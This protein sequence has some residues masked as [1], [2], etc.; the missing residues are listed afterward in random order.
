MLDSKI[1]EEDPDQIELDDAIIST[2]TKT[3]HRV[4]LT[5]QRASTIRVSTSTSM[6]RLPSRTSM[7]AVVTEQAGIGIL[8]DAS[9]SGNSLRP[10]SPHDDD[11]LG[12]PVQCTPVSESNPRE[13][14]SPESHID[15]RLSWLQ[16]DFDSP[17][18]SDRS[19]NREATTGWKRSSWLDDRSHE[20]FHKKQSKSSQGSNEVSLEAR[21]RAVKPLDMEKRGE[22]LGWDLESNRSELRET[23]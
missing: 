16:L 19:Q 15:N 11:D 20:E 23:W 17:T 14:R 6:I 22:E 21:E 1:E 8:P 13:I 10:E 2:A 7:A 12:L 3:A 5:P 18:E 9:S 4:S